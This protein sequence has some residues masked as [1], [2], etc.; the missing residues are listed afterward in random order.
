MNRD[1]AQ[2][3]MMAAIDGELDSAGRAELEAYLEA[4]PDARAEFDAMRGL[5]ERAEHLRLAE[6]PPEVWD[7]YMTTLQPKLERGAGFGLL[8]AGGAGLA[9]AFALIF[10]K[11]PA[12]APGIKLLV[13]AV[14]AGLSVL[15]LSVWREKRHVGRH[16]RYGR[17]RR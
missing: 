5:A 1:E 13:G 11:T 3:R 7:T 15:F 12:I 4:E 14:L 8:I 9:L 17:V 10:L 6:P 2:Q 16:E